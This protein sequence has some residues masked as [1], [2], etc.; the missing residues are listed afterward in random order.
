M[1][2][3]VLILLAVLGIACAILWGFNRMI[4]PER[5][6]KTHP[7][8]PETVS[9]AAPSPA[10]VLPPLPDTSV[11]E[12]AP[13]PAGVANGAGVPDPAKRKAGVVEATGFY[14][15][16]NRAVPESPFNKGVS[17]TGSAKDERMFQLG[18]DE[19]SN[20]WVMRGP[21]LEVEQYER[22]AKALDIPQD[23]VDLD[24]LL[25]SVSEDWLRGYGVSVHFQDGASW[26][27]LF[28][29]DAEGSTLRF[30]SHSVAIDAQLGESN[31]AVRLVSSPV[32]RTVTGEK[33]EFSAD[34]KV[35]VAILARGEGVVSTSYEYR[36]VGLGLNGL[37][38]KMGDG[39]YKLDLTQRNGAVDAQAGAAGQPPQLREQVLKTS[40]MLGLSEW[41]CVG[42]VR[43]WRVET[44]K[45][46]LGKEEKEEQE[47]LLVFC[48]PRMSLGSIPKAWPVG[49]GPEHL[50]DIGP[51]VFE[52]G[53]AHPLLPDPPAEGV[54]PKSLADLEAEFFE[55]RK[56]AKPKAKARR[57][58]VGRM[59]R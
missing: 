1:F 40:I 21:P 36:D 34:T 47:L 23:E 9:A 16:M 3:L 5:R 6:L 46:L 11:I 45:R 35:P 25:V 43:S 31:A 38:R 57:V 48:R 29:I 30:A 44:R 26:A 8:K 28:G 20:A 51:D 7:E 15:F 37:I 17:T 50:S 14:V 19:V 59:G 10:P 54:G 58:P 4:S 56:D 22:M 12:G 39:Q 24:F 42:G 32:V 53:S 18:V 49:E 27:S 13:I 52:L 41:S 55:E 2:R 33:W